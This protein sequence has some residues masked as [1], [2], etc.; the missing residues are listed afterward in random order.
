MIAAF[1][2]FGQTAKTPA[3]IEHP[4]FALESA[5][6]E[7]HSFESTLMGRKMPYRVLLNAAYDANKDQRFPVIYLLHGLFGH[8]DNWTDKTEIEKYAASHNFIIVTPEGGDGWYT[9]SVT[10]KND[11]YESYITRELIPAIDKKFKTVA[12]RE[13]RVI[14]GLSMGGYGAVKFGL[15]YP[16]MFSL[17]GSFSGA[18]DA[19]KRGLGGAKTWPSILSVFGPDDSETRKKNDIFAILNA[20][21]EERRRSIPFIYLDCGTEDF[22]FQTNREFAALLADK[23]VPHEYRQRP[24]THDWEYW[25]EQVEEF[26]E[27]ADKHLSSK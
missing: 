27:V 9:D 17:V 2:A 8:F 21:S 6:V 7:S 14:A 1:A 11:L 10:A 20:M 5:R 3:G 24:G 26:L 23:K 15:K 19:P 4:P 25:G 12:G 13:G 22:L 18:F 16:E